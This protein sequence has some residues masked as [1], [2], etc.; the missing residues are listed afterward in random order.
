[1]GQREMNR[2][3]LEG[4]LH[5]YFRA[6]AGRAEPSP[7][8]WRRALTHLGEQKVAR[9][10]PFAARPLRVF[11]ATAGLALLVGFVALLV[12]APWQGAPQAS[13]RGPAGAR[14]LAGP[15]GPAGAAPAL[16]ATGVTGNAGWNMVTTSGSLGAAE[17]RV[18]VTL[19]D[20][21]SAALD[22]MI[23]YQGDLALAIKDDLGVAMDGVARVA[24]ERGGFVASSSRQGEESATITVRVPSDRFEDTKQAARSL[25]VR[26]LSESS[27]SQDV[28]EEYVDLQ[29]QARN[30]EAAESQ[31]LELV[32]KAQNVEETLK[33]QQQLVSVRG[34]IERIKGRMQYLE[35][36]SSLASLTVSLRPASN[37]GPLVSTDWSATETGRSALRSLAE[38]GQRLAGVAI[39]AGVYSPVWVLLGVVV[40]LLGRR[41]VRS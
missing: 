28:T 27:R 15:A 20:S 36:T 30:W 17:T 41:L 6:E 9:Q 1:M 11:V 13:P 18:R 34:E 25:A 33:V 16:T 21:E 22:R 37:P 23:V 24:E 3:E 31:Y 29:S 7:E 38:F 5:D 35:R 40:V 32:R 39:W 19:S 26:V 4:K 10:W 8:W 14:G 12:A 2:E